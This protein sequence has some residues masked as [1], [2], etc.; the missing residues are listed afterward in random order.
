L[1]LSMRLPRRRFSPP[2]STGR[3]LGHLCGEK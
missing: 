3:D 1:T 2:Q